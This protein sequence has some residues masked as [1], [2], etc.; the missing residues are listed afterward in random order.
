MAMMRLTKLLAAAQNKLNVTEKIHPE[1]QRAPKSDDHRGPSS[2]TPDAAEGF[3]ALFLNDLSENFGRHPNARRYT[4]ETYAAAF[5]IRT[6]SSQAYEF[7]RSLIP[8]PQIKHIDEHFKAALEQIQDQTSNLA[9]LR[10]MLQTYRHLHVPD[11]Y[12][13]GIPVGPPDAPTAMAIPSI[14]GVDA[15]AIEPYSEKNKR[16]LLLNQI[17]HPVTP[18]ELRQLEEGAQI[19]SYFFVFNLMPLDP[20]LPNLVVSVVPHTNSKAN[21]TSNEHLRLIKSICA[22]AGFPVVAFSGDGDNAYGEFLRPLYAEI[23][24]EE[25]K[26]KTFRELIAQLR[27]RDDLFITDF[28]HFIKCLRTRLANHPVSIHDSLPPVLADVLTNLLPIGDALKPKSNGA[29]LKDAVALRVFTLENL[30]TLITHNLIHEALYFLPIVFWRVANQAMNITRDARISLLDVSFE[31]ARKCA[32]WSEHS[33]LPPTGPFG[34]RVFFWR[35]EDIR[36]LMVSL[37]VMGVVLSLPIS[38]IAINRI[39]TID[40]EHLFGVTRQGTHSDN[41]HAKIMR[42]LVKANLVGQIAGNW[43]WF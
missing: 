21:E 22:S 33:G 29:Q 28:L 26:H 36:K 40:L 42:R 14:L 3:R 39:G 24:S 34:A 15:M 25:G 20:T 17:G 11:D 23:Q 19:S 38:R 13:D 2:P 27:D 41:R 8:L 35:T 18:D 10:D 32:E 9:S 31:A 43:G 5:I 1:L 6:M 7:L 30:F 16:L 37:I 4:N 12:S